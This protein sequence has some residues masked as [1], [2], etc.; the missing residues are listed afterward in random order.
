MTSPI[1]ADAT[2]AKAR[3]SRLTALRPPFLASFAVLAIALALE[4]ALPD[5]PAYAVRD[6]SV[7][8]AILLLLLAIT[9]GYFLLAGVT[10][11]AEGAEAGSFFDL[12]AVTGV[13]LLVWLLVTAKLNWTDATH[14]PSPA[15]TFSILSEDLVELRTAFLSSLAKLVWGYFLGLSFAIPIGMVTGWIKRLH[16]VVYPI[17]KFVAPIPP[18]VYIP[19]ALVIFPT[20]EMT[21]I[22]IIFLGVFWP[23][24][25]NTIYGVASVDR[26]LVEAA[27]TL[28]ANTWIILRRVVMPAAMPS[29]FAG[30]LV[31]TILAFIMLTVAETIGATTGLGYYV[32]YYKD[33]ADYNRVLADI[34]VIGAWV[35]AWT[36]VFDR[37]QRWMLRW[38]DRT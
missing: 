10:R 12:I 30:V 18:N 7:F 8:L 19:F 11:R 26:R 37:V 20:M 1:T 24:F 29:I 31:G 25:T 16:N 33:I 23:V 4:I 38:Q 34:F 27:R 21:A 6:K 35:F 36:Y 5:A 14:W 17:A 9:L 3:A 32:L 22:F 15:R 28:G 13:I 2:E